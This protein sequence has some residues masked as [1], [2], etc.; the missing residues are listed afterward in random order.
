MRAPVIAQPGKSHHGKRDVTILSSFAVNVQEH[1]V[2]VD[3][4]N[5]QA[6]AFKKAQATRVYRDE[7]GAVDGK[8][9]TAE[10]AVDRNLSR[11]SRH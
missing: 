2:A 9:D 11:S 5:L 8:P 1:P 3:I 7:A 10:N 4:G 6:R